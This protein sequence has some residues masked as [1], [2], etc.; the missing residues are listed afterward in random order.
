MG[1]HSR[2]NSQA[3]E[4]RND[5]RVIGKLRLTIERAKCTVVVDK[6]VLD[7][8]FVMVFIHNDL[9]EIRPFAYMSV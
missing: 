7:C 5:I 3:T 6:T 2:R 9:A 1:R 8:Y 4:I